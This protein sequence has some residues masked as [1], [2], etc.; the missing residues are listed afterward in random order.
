MDK[1]LN[2]L[3]RRIIYIEDS[4][5]EACLIHSICRKLDVE[6]HWLPNLPSL[7]IYPVKLLK[8]F[9]FA[10][11]DCRGVTPEIDDRPSKDYSHDSIKCIATSSDT[12]SFDN[13]KFLLKGDVKEYLRSIYG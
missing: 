9:D 1:P 4:P 5:I 11:V 6:M 13:I 10:L 3:T 8:K 12:L 7:E 2:P